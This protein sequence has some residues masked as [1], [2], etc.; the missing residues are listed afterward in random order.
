MRVLPLREV[1]PI[2]MKIDM[3]TLKATNARK[4]VIILDETSLL[5]RSICILDL[6]KFMWI[7]MKQNY[8]K[9]V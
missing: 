2:R 3:T 1:Q 9:H 4:R 7:H 8:D 6:D 5:D